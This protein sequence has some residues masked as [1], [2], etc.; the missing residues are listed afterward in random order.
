MP[1]DVTIRRTTP[2]RS[3]TASPSSTVVKM[4]GG[5]FRMMLN[6]DPGLP[7]IPNGWLSRAR[8]VGLTL[9]QTQVG[10]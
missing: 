3:Q 4:N 7:G 10:E 6:G 1:V 5:V 2:I 8:P 9:G